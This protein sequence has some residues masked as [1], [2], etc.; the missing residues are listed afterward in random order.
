MLKTEQVRIVAYMVEMHCLLK[1]INFDSKSQDSYSPQPSRLSQVV[2]NYNLISNSIK[3]AVS[4]F[5]HL[6]S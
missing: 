6:I 4:S 5:F 3:F 2:K 1:M